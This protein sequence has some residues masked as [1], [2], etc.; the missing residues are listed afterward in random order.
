MPIKK[1]LGRPPKN[2]KEEIIVE[3]IEEISKHSVT[4]NN[5]EIKNVTDNTIGF[6]QSLN[7]KKLPAFLKVYF[8]DG[9]CYKVPTR[10]IIFEISKKNNKF[11]EEYFK[12][13]DDFEIEIRKFIEQLSWLDI[14]QYAYQFY[15]DVIIDEIE[16]WKLC[17]KVFDFEDKI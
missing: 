5:I 11:N 2:K 8:C 7:N 13:C 9:R 15:R 10:S 17:K 1:K 14:Q 6:L 3:E 16:E 4:E 12:N